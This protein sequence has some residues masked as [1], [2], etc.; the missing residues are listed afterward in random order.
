MQHIG[1][2]L[3]GYLWH[4]KADG[5]KLG[6]GGEGVTPKALNFE[7]DTRMGTPLTP[8]SAA[9][10]IDPACETPTSNLSLESSKGDI[11]ALK[12]F[13]RLVWLLAGEEGAGQKKARQ[14]IMKL[15]KV[16]VVVEAMQ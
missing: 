3:L 13:H 5:D 12:V 15:D 1:E 9:T 2:D 6:D 14:T 8:A 11:L 4:P 7:G 10:T 16:V